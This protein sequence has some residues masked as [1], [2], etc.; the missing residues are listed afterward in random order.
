MVESKDNEE[1]DWEDEVELHM[2][3]VCPLFTTP[4]SCYQTLYITFKRDYYRNI[5][6]RSKEEHY[7]LNQPPIRLLKEYYSERIMMEFS[8]DA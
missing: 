4:D 1:Q 7:V 2:M 5:G 6:I 8:L 3:D